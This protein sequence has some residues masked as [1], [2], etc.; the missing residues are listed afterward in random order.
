[1]EPGAQ[2]ENLGIIVHYK[3]KVRLIV[4]YGGDL[5]VELPFILTHPKPPEPSPAS[6]PAMQR[7]YSE[8]ADEAENKPPVDSDLIKFDTDGPEKNPQ[9]DDL[10]FEEFARMRVRGEHLGDS[11][12]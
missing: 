9:D 1:M 4:A 7:R 10:I 6:S 8:I 2:K 5:A 12:A 11:N 3:V